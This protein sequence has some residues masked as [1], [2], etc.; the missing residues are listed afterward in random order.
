M[1]ASMTACKEK[2]KQNKT[3]KLAAILNLYLKPHANTADII[4]NLL[5]HYEQTNHCTNAHLIVVWPNQAIDLIIGCGL[6]IRVTVFSQ[7]LA[8]IP[9]SSESFLIQ[10]NMDGWV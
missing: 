8:G 4:H 7:G 9:V 1:K 6:R 3:E 2:K 5:G 10:V